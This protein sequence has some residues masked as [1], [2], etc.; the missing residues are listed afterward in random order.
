MKASYKKLK[1]IAKLHAIKQDA[2]NAMDA[3][4]AKD[5]NN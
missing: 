3:K 2:K 4:K 1:G 5:A